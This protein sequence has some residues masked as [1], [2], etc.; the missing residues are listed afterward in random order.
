MK[1]VDS[2]TALRHTRNESKLDRVHTCRTK[3]ISRF[4]R[5][6]QWRLRLV[7]CDGN[8]RRGHLSTS[9]EERRLQHDLFLHPGLWRSCSWTHETR[10]KTGWRLV[11]GKSTPNVNHSARLQTCQVVWKALS[12][13]NWNYNWQAVTDT[14]IQS[15]VRSLARRLTP[16]HCDTVTRTLARVGHTNRLDLRNDI[17]HFTTI[18][19]NVFATR[20]L[21]AGWHASICLTLVKSAY[22]LIN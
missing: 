20:Q 21:L 17:R 6:H 2:N 12:R 7:Y 14:N 11:G 15:A 3:I 18:V 22:A 16:P 1:F 5:L 4:V 13:N 19:D 10:R 9:R 8:N